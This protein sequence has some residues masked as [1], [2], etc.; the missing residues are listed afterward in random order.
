[1]V[2]LKWRHGVAAALFA[3]RSCQHLHAQ[4][5]ME[6]G[7]QLFTQTAVPACAA[8]HTLVHADAKGA[9]GPNLDELKPDAARVERAVRNGV[10]QMPAFSSLSDEQIQALA[11]YVS[12][13]AARSK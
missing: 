11:Q 7:K 6:A 1:M 4:D 3:A 5:K 12:R 9:I 2:R 13:V 10:G 8:C